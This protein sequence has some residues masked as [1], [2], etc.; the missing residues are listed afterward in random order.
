M[1]LSDALCTFSSGLDSSISET[2]KQADKFNCSD[3]KYSVQGPKVWI[4]IPFKADTLPPGTIEVQGDNNGLTAMSVHSVL[5]DGSIRSANYSEKAVRE[6]WRP[7]GQYGLPVPGSDNA[8]LRNDIKTV[9][10]SID[11]PRVVSS[12]S[13]SQLASKKVWDDR[14]LPLS[15]M[16]AIL[17]GMAV[18]PLIYNAFF[19]SALRYNFM[20]WHSV[21]AAATT[22]YTF[23]SSGLIF[24]AF[25]ETTLTTKFLLNYWTLAFGIAASG[26]FLI[27]FLERGKISWRLQA[28]ILVTALFP[29]AA[30]AIILHGN[31]G[32]NMYARNQYHASFLPYF[33][34]I[35]YTM[36]HAIRRGSRAIWFQV[37]A[38]SPIIFFGLDRIARG[39][40]IYIGI[41]ALDYGLYFTLVIETIILAFG[42][43]N[44]ILQLRRHH[45]DSMR[46]QVELTL[47]ADTDGLTA[48]GNRRAFERAF[49]DKSPEY[50]FDHLAILDIDFFKHVNDE[51]GHETGD[52]VLRAVGKE[53]ANTRHFV[54]RIGGEE[55]ALLMKTKNRANRG[56]SSAVELS[57]ICQRL[58]KAVHSD[59]PQIKRAV[60]FSVGVTSIGKR[61]S[62]RSVMAVADKRLYDAKNNGRNQI[63]S[64]DISDLPKPHTDAATA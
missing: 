29:V 41:P 26:F 22:I 36:V 23:S 46:K 56:S 39:M 49:H 21:M 8:Q 33:F 27:G 64:F 54:A 13:I 31:E 18:M 9:Y 58:I 4:K 42:V 12:I 25:P 7:K 35:I 44:R 48:I 40:D 51:Y 5:E 32:Y 3:N 19:Y 2:L 57:E 38:W 30:T 1:P 53:L 10:V 47:L 50:R 20:L 6:H 34:V 24:I 17:C 63:V 11:H 55:F 16:F 52:D 59:V 45:E 60:T 28:V 62:L 61:A 37:A 14:K 43:A 15:V